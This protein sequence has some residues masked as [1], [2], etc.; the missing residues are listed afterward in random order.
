MRLIRIAWRNV[1]RNGRRSGVTI[2]AMSLGLVVMILWSALVQGY[3]VGMEQRILELELGDM[4]IFALDYE[5][6]PSVYTRI[7][8]S[9]TVVESLTRAGLRAAPRL[10]AWGLASVDESSA[11]ASLRGIDVERERDVSEIHEHVLDGRWLRPGED[12][13]VVLGRRLVRTLGASVGD[14]LF[15]LSQGADG[16]MAYGLYTVVGILGNVGD[17][18][19][20][21]AVFLTDA[22]YR[23]LMAV[24]GG[25]HQIVVRRPDGVE[26]DPAAGN[27]RG[28][29]PGLDVKT[30]REIAP[31]LAS[32]LDSARSGMIVMVLIVYITIAILILNAM[33]M[34]V[35]ERVREFGVLKALGAGPGEVLAMVWLESAIQVGLAVAIGL[36]IGWPGAWLLERH[37]IDMGMVGGTS[38]MGI[39]MD[40]RWYGLITSDVFI[41][42]VAAL[43]AIV[44][45]AVAYPAARA[46][47]IRPVDA[48]RTH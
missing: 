19:D 2:A 11:G 7:E 33:L 10:L 18:T 30:W 39:A 40:E 15:V 20:R 47:L 28:L 34:A 1:W 37:G 14:E 5:R 9:A 4:Q 23:D 3:L 48:M 25:A 13:A 17:L 42:P 36:A 8:D 46:A 26:L 24:P 31:T 45:L 38:I 44:C 16:G 43:L 35:F 27:V 21:T 41:T 12:H 22:A 6:D 32:M 29:L